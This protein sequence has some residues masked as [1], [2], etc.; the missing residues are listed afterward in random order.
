MSAMRAKTSS[1][2]PFIAMQVE[3]FLRAICSMELHC[4][5]Q[6]RRM[7]KP[8]MA[9]LGSA[10]KYGQMGLGPFKPLALLSSGQTDDS[11][12]RLKERPG[13]EEIAHRRAVLH[14]SKGLLESNQLLQPAV[15]FL[16]AAAQRQLAQIAQTA[17]RAAKFVQLGCVQLMKAPGAAEQSGLDFLAFLQKLFP[18][19]SRTEG[20]RFPRAKLF[21]SRHG[22]RG[23]FRAGETP[24]AGPTLLEELIALGFRGV[25]FQPL[26]DDVLIAHA[27]ESIGGCERPLAQLGDPAFSQHRPADSC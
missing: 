19:F 13:R 8:A 17:E 25:N 12:L 3:N 5:K 15:V 20:G 24:K 1:R 16:L 4:A 18:H 9:A 21:P 7:I 2:G 6:I 27:A 14:F 26:E 22:E 11:G 10:A 23:Q